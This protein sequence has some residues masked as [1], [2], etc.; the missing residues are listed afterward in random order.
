MQT[1]R[2]ML[3]TRP[4][5]LGVD[6]TAGPLSGASPALVEYHA[7]HEDEID[8]QE[9]EQR[10]F[11][12]CK[13]AAR[14]AVLCLRGDELVRFQRGDDGGKF[15]GST[16]TAGSPPGAEFEGCSIYL[17][18]RNASACGAIT[19]TPNNNPAAIS[20]MTTP[21]ARTLAHKGLINSPMISRSL[22]SM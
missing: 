16:L 12:G 11:G 4:A 7:E 17:P 8:P 22:T 18:P 20:T 15:F 21:K 5:A 3:Q 2:D 1:G 9:P 14:N 13:R 19:L 10:D 6:V